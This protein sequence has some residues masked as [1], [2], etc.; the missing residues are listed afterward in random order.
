MRDIVDIGQNGILI[1]AVDKA[2]VLVGGGVSNEQMDLEHA[3]KDLL[4][5]AVDDRFRQ[6][7]LDG[8]ADFARRN[9]PPAPPAVAYFD[10]D[11]LL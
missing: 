2:P 5:A 9:A 10:H 6:F 4:G 3:G 8:L 1:A 7:G 11:V